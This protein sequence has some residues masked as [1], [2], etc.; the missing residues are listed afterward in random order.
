MTVIT[1]VR[2]TVKAEYSAQ[3]QEYISRVVDELRTLD[4]PDI[5][6]SVFVEDD[7]RTFVHL[8]L[9]A[10]EEAERAFGTLK[11]Q[12]AFQA[13]L[14][15]SRPEGPTPMTNLSLVSSTSNLP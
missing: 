15:A 2:Y 3:N 10:N 14:Q 9:C 11:S 6:Y 7:R 13:A 8:L 4:Q 12:Q 1:H 5:S